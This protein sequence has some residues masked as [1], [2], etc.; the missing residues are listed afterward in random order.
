MDEATLLSELSRLHRAGYDAWA[1][2]GEPEALYDVLSGV[3]TGR[4]LTEQY[5]RQRVAL[6]RLHAAKGGLS[7]RGHRVEEATLMALDADGAT[8]R[9]RWLVG[10]LVTHEGHSHARIS[11]YEAVYELAFTAEGP[12]LAG[13]WPKDQRRLAAPPPDAEAWFA[14]EL[15]DPAMGP[16]TDTTSTLD[17]LR[18]GL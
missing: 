9:L 16:N 15:V 18:G 7:L 14:Q 1:T 17:V 6:A 13:V 12:R 2:E 11:R 5:I 10:G 3:W 8:V 4:A